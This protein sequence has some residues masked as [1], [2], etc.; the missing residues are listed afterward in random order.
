MAL[1]INALVRRSKGDWL[2]PLMVGAAVGALCASAFGLGLMDSWSRRATDKLFLP[3]TADTRIAI[4]A[5]DDASLARLGRWPWPRSTHAKIIENISALQPL[6]IGYDVNFPEPSNAADDTALANAI[7]ESGKVVLPVELEVRTAADAVY[8]DSSKML[9]PIPDIAASAARLGH[10]NQQPDS[11]GIVRRVALETISADKSRVASFASQVAEVGGVT[12]DPAYGTDSQKRLIISYPDAPGKG[13]INWY[14]AA[15][16]FDRSVRLDSLHGAFVLVGATAPDLHDNVIAP[17][18]GGRSMPGVEVHASILDTLLQHR[19]LREVPIWLTALLLILLG[20]LVGLFVP[21][22]R[23]RWSVLLAVGIW[24]AWLVAAFILFDRGWVL[25]LV[26]PTFALFL[27]YAAV[28]MERRIAS[29]RQKREIRNAFSR[30]VSKS[31]V[32]SILDNPSRLKLGGE[33]RRMTV[34]FS[35]VRGFTTISEGLKP[36]KL[37]EVMNTYLTSMTDIVFNHQGVLDKYIGD[38]VMAF[39]N[40]P[41]DQPDHAD[42]AVQTALDMLKTLKEMNAAGKFGDLQ[43][44][45]GVGVNTGEMVVGNM[46]SE[47]RFDYTVIGDSVNLGSRMESLTKEYGVALLI[48]EATRAE[49]KE[50]YLMRSVDLV[51]V[52]GKKEPVRMFELMMREADASPADNALVAR[53]GEAMQSYAARA[54]DKA[55]AIT[56]DLMAQYPDDGPTKTLNARA[57][58][59]MQEPPPEDWNGVWVMTKK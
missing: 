1:N 32:Q 52:K 58:H 41:F 40:A 44:K 21:Y 5:I 17:T 59:F 8:F 47:E 18:S 13:F 55:V 22:I 29:E 28:I 57:K 26:W 12:V 6:A 24:V 7:K 14:S 56:D 46:G 15:D 11:D 20:M 54:F 9:R 38:A 27:A 19:F 39:W 43:F 35:D 31:V 25:E 34:L 3:R 16:V 10:V 49:L 2:R 53:F 33:R 48:S 50:R 37:V 4:V 42:R 45:I 30:Y 23:M 36:E 51:A